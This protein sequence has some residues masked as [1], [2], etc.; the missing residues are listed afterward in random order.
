MTRKKW[1]KEEDEILVKYYSVE[2]TEVVNRLSDRT[3][4]AIKNRAQA[5]GLIHRQEMFG[6]TAEEL[7]ILRKYYPSEGK[8]VANRLPGRTVRTIQIMAFREGVKRQFHH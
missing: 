4:N 3:V 5:L 6:W 8:R 1:T 7:E 2:G